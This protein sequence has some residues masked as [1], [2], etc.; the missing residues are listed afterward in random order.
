M[1]HPVV[2]SC[3]LLHL[4]NLPLLS[5]L[6]EYCPCL[7]W[8]GN[9]AAALKQPT[10]KKEQSGAGKTHREKQDPSQHPSKRPKLDDGMLSNLP[11]LLPIAHCRVLYLVRIHSQLQNCLCPRSRDRC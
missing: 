2:T 4:Y 3:C 6:A 7:Q 5:V 8:A 11:W 9:Y 1:R 10:S